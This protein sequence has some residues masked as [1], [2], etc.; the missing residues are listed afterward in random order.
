[1]NGLRQQES[2]LFVVFNRL[3][4][5]RRRRRQLCSLQASPQDGLARGGGRA[6]S[7]H[8]DDEDAANLFLLSCSSSS[9]SI[10]I[11]SS[12]SH[13]ASSQ[14]ALG[15]PQSTTRSDDFRREAAETK[16]KEH[17]L[18]AN[19]YCLSFSCARALLPLVIII[20]A[21]YFLQPTRSSGRT[22]RKLVLCR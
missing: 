18:T 20:A 21:C 7:M 1:M 6:R 3:Q 15:P 17:N 2:S 10:S 19:Q 9:V 13:S 11:S 16:R 5:L 22:V 8:D 4:E 12:H 14:F